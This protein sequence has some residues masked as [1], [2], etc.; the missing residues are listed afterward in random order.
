MTNF[1]EYQLNRFASVSSD[2]AGASWNVINEVTGLTVSIDPFADY[3]T[4]RVY[5][6]YKAAKAAA[7]HLKLHYL[8]V[9]AGRRPPLRS[10]T[11]GVVT[12]ENRP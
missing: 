2:D 11:D 5:P 6:T 8:A 10:S 4:P 9:E 7:A 3:P 1:R 12:K